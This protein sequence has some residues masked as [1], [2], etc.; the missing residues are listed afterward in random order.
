M[1]WRRED[2]LED[3]VRTPAVVA[4]RIEPEPLEVR[5]PAVGIGLDQRRDDDGEDARVPGAGGQLGN[6]RLR[7]RRTL[8]DRSGGSFLRVEVEF[9]PL[10]PRLQRLRTAEEPAERGAE[11]RVLEQ[12]EELGVVVE[13][14]GEAPR[15]YSPGMTRA[16]STAIGLGPGA[17][18]WRS[19]P[20]KTATRITSGASGRPQRSNQAASSGTP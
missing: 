6:G 7:R 10:L 4:G 17:A 3:L 9:L 16:P 13:P 18:S 12:H 14:A 5:L 2:P 20:T 19:L 11:G 8:P 1:P 15:G